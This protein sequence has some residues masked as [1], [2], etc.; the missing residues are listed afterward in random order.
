MQPIRKRTRAPKSTIGAGQ[1]NG[2]TRPAPRT[3]TDCVDTVAS[4]QAPLIPCA[5]VGLS[6]R[7][8]EEKG[9]HHQHPQADSGREADLGDISPA[10]DAQTLAAENVR[11]CHQGEIPRAARVIAE[12]GEEAPGKQGGPRAGQREEDRVEDEIR[13]QEQPR[14]SREAE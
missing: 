12:I 7:D 14:K 1:P 3:A 11:R 9:V 8:G 6:S 2:S 13:R 5:S 10:G 4:S